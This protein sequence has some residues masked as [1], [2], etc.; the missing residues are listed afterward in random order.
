MK[1]LSSKMSIVLVVSALAFLPSCDWLKNKLGMVKTD[2]AQA[3]AADAHDEVVAMIDGKPLLY[4]SEVN[5]QLKT[6][7]EMNPQ[8]AQIE[9]IEDH[10]AN[11]LAMQKLI[12]RKVNEEGL[13]K[14][15]EYQQQLESFTH[16]LNWRT[17]AAKHQPVITEED[18]KAYYDKNKENLA[19]AMVSRGGVPV[20]SVSFAKEAD[21]KAFLEKA[22]VKVGQL[23]QVAKDAKLAEKFR[24]YKLVHANSYGIEPVLREKVLAIK[25]SPATEVIKINDST[26][27]VVHVGAKEAAKYR[28][29]EEVKGAI[30]QRLAGEK[31]NESLEK[32]LEQLKKDFKFEMKKAA[33]A[34]P[35]IENDQQL[36]VVMPEKTAQ[37]KSHAQAPARAA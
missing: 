14:S 3:V 21:A 27:Y 23:E 13:N 29:Y 24:D 2:Q 15:K 37:E 6:I 22:K 32:A 18:K 12:S 33:P 8:I 5:N 26:Y 17:F 19:E 35:E 36:E 9:G 7:I 31:Q 34:V 30:E 1:N 4:R 11:S 10:L 28:A 16:M 25:K 20:S